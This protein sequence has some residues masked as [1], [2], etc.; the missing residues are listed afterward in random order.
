MV[1]QEEIFY[2]V[3]EEVLLN[4]VP[5]EQR[6]SLSYNWGK[7][8]LSRGNSM[9]KCPEASACLYY[10]AARGQQKGAG[11]SAGRKVRAVA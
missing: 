5:M 9:C 4:Q 6:S 8:V 11:V 10:R 7:S 3:G 2:M 1:A